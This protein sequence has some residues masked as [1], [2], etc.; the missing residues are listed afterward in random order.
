M[1]ALADLDDPPPTANLLVELRPGVSLQM[2]FMRADA[3][4]ECPELP[5]LLPMP[6]T[7]ALAVSKLL[8]EDM[9]SGCSEPP[10]TNSVPSG[11]T[12]AQRDAVLR[13][14]ESALVRG[15]PLPA[16]RLDGVDWHAA[17]VKKDA[18]P[19]TELNAAQLTRLVHATE[20]PDLCDCLLL[21]SFPQLLDVEH[22][23][24]VAEAPLLG[25]LAELLSLLLH[26]GTALRKSAA[27]FQQQVVDRLH[28]LSG[29]G[30]G[31]AKQ[32]VFVFAS[33]QS[34]PN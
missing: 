3:C 24:E 17:F 30:R 34:S 11:C 7:P 5:Y 23:E 32:A 21:H 14:I 18:L 27:E 12:S 22:A 8:A 13:S 33:A 6:E 31:A 20:S 1:E 16:N 26:G 19:L 2:C 4:D 29:L 15:E 9:L 25:P 10:E 28:G